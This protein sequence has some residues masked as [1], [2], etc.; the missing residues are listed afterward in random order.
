MQY[1]Y[2]HNQVHLLF[3]DPS[4]LKK[5]KTTTNNKA[6]KTIDDNF[7]KLFDGNTIPKIINSDITEACTSKK[8][9]KTVSIY[10]TIKFIKN[11]RN[12]PPG[13]PSGSDKI[14]SIGGKKVFKRATPIKTSKKVILWLPPKKKPFITD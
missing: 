6:E 14:F 2:D 8:G 9:S 12:M 5:L 10:K 13:P 4:H 3:D 1:L 7:V 11:E